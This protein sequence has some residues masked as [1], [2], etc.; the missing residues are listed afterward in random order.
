MLVGT[1]VRSTPVTMIVIIRVLALAVRIMPV[2]RPMMHRLTGFR[3][4]AMVRH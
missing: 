1:I 3:P 2:V 4:I